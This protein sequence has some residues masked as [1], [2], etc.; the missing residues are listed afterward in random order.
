MPPERIRVS[1][2]GYIHE[3]EAVHAV[4]LVVHDYVR[5]PQ[6]QPLRDQFGQTVLA[7]V[8]LKDAPPIG[9]K[10]RT[11]SGHELYAQEDQIEVLEA[12]EVLP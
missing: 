8:G 4:R 5:D 1:R 12:G 11:D 9:L 7:E 2:H 10:F 3:G 6:G